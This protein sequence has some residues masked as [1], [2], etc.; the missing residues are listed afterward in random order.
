[1]NNG[2]V[3]VPTLTCLPAMICDQF[4]KKIL[5]FYAEKK[6]NIKLPIIA[7]FSQN[8]KKSES[9]CFYVVLCLVTSK[10]IPHTA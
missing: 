3:A 6:Q 9:V 2:G 8:V 5:T 7:S 10:I 4:E 1:M